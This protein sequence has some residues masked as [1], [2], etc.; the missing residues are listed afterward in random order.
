[1]AGTPEY[2]QYPPGFVFTQV[3]TVALVGRCRAPTAK[4]I[5]PE[6][7]NRRLNRAPAGTARSAG[8]NAVST[9]G[10]P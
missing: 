6:I 7:I 10:Y 1:M 3:L 9:P 5:L 2:R 4:P 8:R